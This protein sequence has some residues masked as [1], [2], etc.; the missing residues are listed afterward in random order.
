MSSPLFGRTVAIRVRFPHTRSPHTQNPL[1]EIQIH[2]ETTEDKLLESIKPHLPIYA[3]NFAR[4]VEEI[5]RDTGENYQVR[6]LKAALDT[7]VEKEAEKQT[8]RWAI[9][10]FRCQALKILSY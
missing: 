7:L 2:R 4:A 10:F 3:A 5:N 6:T 1:D 8:S 9:S